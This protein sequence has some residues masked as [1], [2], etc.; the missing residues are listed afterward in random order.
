[1]AKDNIFPEVLLEEPEEFRVFDDKVVICF[2]GDLDI[3]FELDEN[4][5]PASRNP[6]TTKTFIKPSV[7]AEGAICHKG[8]E[9]AQLS[10]SVIDKWKS[11]AQQEAMS[12]YRNSR[13][14]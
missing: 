2:F 14:R 5:V 13:R 4:E 8:E 9:I 7:K 10:R 1:M 12:H 11:T 6:N 3:K